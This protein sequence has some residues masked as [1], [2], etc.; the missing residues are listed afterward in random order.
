MESKFFL[1]LILIAFTMTGCESQEP[2]QEAQKAVTADEVKKEVREAVDT[3]GQFADDKKLQYQESLEAKLQALSKKREE[4]ESRIN[5]A[6][7]KVQ[8]KARARLAD[9]RSKQEALNT[10]LDNLGTSTGEGWE[11]MRSAMDEAMEELEQGY[12]RALEEF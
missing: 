5:S 4:L 9:L 7:K 12:D 2:A 1:V 3:L 8:D 10:K 11:E 6:G